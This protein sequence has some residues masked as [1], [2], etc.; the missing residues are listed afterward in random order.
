MSCQPGQACD[1]CASPCAPGTNAID[2]E[3]LHKEL[4]AL[5]KRSKALE[6]QLSGLSVKDDGDVVAPEPE[7]RLRSTRW[8]N[9]PEN[10]AM[11]V[12]QTSPG[13]LQDF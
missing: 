7:P 1:D 3:D 10:Q 2:I 5:R 11:S 13:W 12:E 6:E 8:F 9:H 4:A